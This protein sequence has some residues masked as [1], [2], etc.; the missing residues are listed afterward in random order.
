M[1]V[2]CHMV[3]IICCIIKYLIQ[4]GVA[5][6]IDSS[7]VSHGCHYLSHHEYVI[8]RGVTPFNNGSMVSHGCHYLSHHTYVIRSGV[9]PFSNGSMVSHGCHYLSHC[10]VLDKAWCGTNN[11]W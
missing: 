1:V 9:T 7:M 5:S 6:L 8:R 10:K 3:V 11:L 4:R 2:W